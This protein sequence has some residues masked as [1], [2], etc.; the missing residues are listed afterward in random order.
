[1]SEPTGDRFAEAWRLNHSYLVDLAFRMLGDVGTAEDVVQ[2]AFTRL[3]RTEDGDIQD[4]RGWLT[5]VTGRLCLDQ[6][7]SARSRRE[8]IQETA[9]L[10]SLAPPAQL[11]PADRI[12]LDDSVR[13]ALFVVLERL[14][15]AERV[16]FVL[17]DVFQLPF[18]AI[19]ETLG[20]PVM[21][22]RQLARR[23]RN[24][25]ASVPGRVNDV[26][27]SEHRLL[28]EKFIAACANG[29]FDA[30]L[31]VLHPQAW[32]MAEFVEGSPIEPQVTHGAR[33]VARALVH[34]YANLTLVSHPPTVLAYSG[35][36]LFA[37]L[38]LTITDGL[39]TQLHGT[40]DP[41]AGGPSI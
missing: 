41:F 40:I 6:I 9:V 8:Q 31:D 35:R 16:A 38:T 21:T 5:V 4:D 33:R 3:S 27:P 2:E 22:C 30:L 32:G 26:A 12:T 17:H 34:Y 15:P 25:I 10:E 19:A 23:A 18:E 20:R 29:D 28:T 11:D 36:R 13:M 7:R 14:S 1:V 24:K 37:V 39:V